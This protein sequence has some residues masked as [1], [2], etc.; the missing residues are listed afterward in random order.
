MIKLRRQSILGNIAGVGKARQMTLLKHF[1]GLTELKG[2]GI[3]DL[4]KIKGISRSLA[5]RIYAYLHA[6]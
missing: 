2:A 3:D 5:E 6:E 4:I 1:G